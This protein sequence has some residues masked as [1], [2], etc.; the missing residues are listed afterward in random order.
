MCG[1]YLVLGVDNLSK[2]RTDLDMATKTQRKVSVSKIFQTVIHCALISASGMGKRCRMSEIR[3]FV[4]LYAGFLFTGSA[5]EAV[6]IQSVQ[7]MRLLEALEA[8]GFVSI[9]KEGA[10]TYYAITTACHVNLLKEMLSTDQRLP[11]EE[12]IFLNYYITTYRRLFFVGGQELQEA[13]RKLIGDLME[14]G[15]FVERQI[16]LL[17]DKIHK[18]EA[19]KTDYAKIRAFLDRE[20]VAKLS[21][22]EKIQQL[23]L[24]PNIPQTYKKSLRDVLAELP[25]PLRQREIER[26]FD[27]RLQYFYV[28]YLRSLINE[29]GLLT[30]LLPD[31]A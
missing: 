9:E 21:I 20:D 11:M 8:D 24:G 30:S 23:P 17:D 13:D 15:R 5:R 2:C 12:V 6:V 31:A 27:Q 16:A 3:F 28:P 10:Q 19:R 25:E 18:I 22:T 14:P 26:G 1:V 7:I 29:R 4:D